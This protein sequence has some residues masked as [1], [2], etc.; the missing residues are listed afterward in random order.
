MILLRLFLP[1]LCDEVN[2]V[3]LGK[4]F[5]RRGEAAETILQSVLE[6][7]SRCNPNLTYLGF[8]KFIHQA[9]CFLLRFIG[10][11]VETVEEDYDFVHILGQVLDFAIIVSQNVAP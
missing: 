8:R 11:L 10:D 7:W 1:E 5:Q 6:M 2:L 4:R 3:F 9:Q